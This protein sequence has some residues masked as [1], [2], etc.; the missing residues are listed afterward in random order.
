MATTLTQSQLEA[1][2]TDSRTAIEQAMT[3]LVTA[4]GVAETLNDYYGAYRD[5]I[6]SAWV[7]G[8]DN[9]RSTLKKAY[10]DIEKAYETELDIMATSAGV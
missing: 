2:I 5:S 7:N 1:L 4:N 6:S 9:V 8:Y 3:N 10:G